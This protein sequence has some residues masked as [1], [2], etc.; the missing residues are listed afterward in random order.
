M[1]VAAPSKQVQLRVVDLGID[2]MERCS[3]GRWLGAVWPRVK[4]KDHEDVSR[5]NCGWFALHR[6]RRTCG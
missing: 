5:S 1:T 6:M 2:N 4:V 3:M